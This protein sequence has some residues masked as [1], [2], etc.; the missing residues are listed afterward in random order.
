MALWSSIV[1]SASFFG[2]E[3]KGFFVSSMWA[4]GFMV[5]LCVADD[6][7]GLE[8]PMPGFDPPKILENDKIVRRY[9]EIRI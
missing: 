1:Y 5:N 6:D 2:A 8:K 3:A 7:G 4:E 9:V